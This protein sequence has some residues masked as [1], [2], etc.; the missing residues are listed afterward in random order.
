[1]EE[2]NY[3]LFIYGDFKGGEKLAY[4]IISTLEPVMSSP[5]IKYIWGDFGIVAHFKTTLSFSELSEYCATALNVWVSQYF[6]VE[7]N[8]GVFGHAEDNNADYL[9]NLDINENI[10]DVYVDEN[11]NQVKDFTDLYKEF[12]NK[13]NNGEI[14]MYSGEDEDEEDEDE[15]DLIIRRNETK[16]VVTLNDIL[17]K[18][19]EKG[20]ESLTNTEKRKLNEYANG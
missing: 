20:I 1:M 12:M 9:L 2:K 8:G 6:L 15:I 18:I 3:M 17:D 5:A 4:E 13:L 19:S 14:Q 11:V 16:D 10:E 7:N